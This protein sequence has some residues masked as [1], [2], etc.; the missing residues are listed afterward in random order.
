MHARANHPLKAFTAQLSV[1][2]KEK[3][4]FRWP[5]PNYP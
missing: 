3:D 2:E 4:V 1:A 5:P